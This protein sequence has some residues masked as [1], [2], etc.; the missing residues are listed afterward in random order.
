MSSCLGPPSAVLRVREPLL[1]GFFLGLGM[2]ALTAAGC[3]GD[4]AV[5]IMPLMRTD[6]PDSEPLVQEVT[7]DEAYYWL[8]GDQ[9]N[10]SLRTHRGAGLGQPF[11]FE[12][13]IS[14]V[15][16]EMPAGSSRLYRLDMDSV[17]MAQTVGADHRR[18]RSWTGVAVIEAPERGRLGGRFHVNV[19]QQ[20]FTLL[21]GWQPHFLQAPMLIVAGR[22][23]ATENAERG[24]DILEET[25]A[26]GFERGTA[27]TAPARPDTP[28][29]I[30]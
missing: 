20:Q 29:V 3:A 28:H 16:D 14:L 18:S 23:Q 8:E 21:G 9:L 27:A 4:G 5:R 19:R 6:F 2:W 13:Q 30:H 17:R 7:V 26:M 1:C 11:D 25:E 22:F 10:V 24:R 15:L 12:W